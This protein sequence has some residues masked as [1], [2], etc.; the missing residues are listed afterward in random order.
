MSM[1]DSKN[2][3]GGIH[4]DTLND[5]FAGFGDRCAERTTLTRRVI[6]IGD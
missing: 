3:F 5:L 6:F 4:E 2:V 1:T